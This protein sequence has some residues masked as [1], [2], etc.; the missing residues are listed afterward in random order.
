MTGPLGG[1][2]ALFQTTL[3]G[4]NVFMRTNDLINPAVD[5]VP[6]L[7]EVTIILLWFHRTWNL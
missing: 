6:S 7:L 1:N 3:G 5:F 2:F 4:A